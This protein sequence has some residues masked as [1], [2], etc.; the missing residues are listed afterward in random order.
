MTRTDGWDEVKLAI[1]LLAA[2]LNGNALMVASI[3][4]DSEPHGLESG[5]IGVGCA[6]VD[7]V[8]AHMGL[9]SEVV[10]DEMLMRL[11]EMENEREAE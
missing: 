8:A 3:M 10:L 7:E 6:L 2:N 4:L 11:A 1:R 9:S 5:L